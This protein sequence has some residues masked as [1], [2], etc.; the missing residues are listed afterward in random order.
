M[1][2]LAMASKLFL[3]SLFIGSCIGPEPDPSNN[4]PPFQ[5]SPLNIARLALESQRSFVSVLFRSDMV[6]EELRKY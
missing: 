3:S 5:N 6:E 4:P 2:F 1:W